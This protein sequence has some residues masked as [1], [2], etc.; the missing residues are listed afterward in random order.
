MPNG[1][2]ERLRG[3]RGIELLVALAV[4]ALLRVVALGLKRADV[5]IALALAGRDIGELPPVADPRT[6]EACR[7]DFRLFFTEKITL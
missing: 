3:A 2:W 7:T 4:A 1:L 5:W 6:K